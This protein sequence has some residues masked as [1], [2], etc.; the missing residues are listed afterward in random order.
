M[1]KSGWIRSLVVVDPEC[2][3]HNQMYLHE[4]DKNHNIQNNVKIQPILVR[5]YKIKQHFVYLLRNE[6]MNLNML[7]LVIKC[8]SSLRETVERIEFLFVLLI[9]SFD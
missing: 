8:G 9:Y 5:Y 7:K 4:I 3:Y 1:S 2:S 6:D